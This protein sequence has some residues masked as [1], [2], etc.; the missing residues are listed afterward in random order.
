MDDVDNNIDWR[1]VHIQ[2]LIKS[3]KVKKE[4]IP[5]IIKKQEIPVMNTKCPLIKIKGKKFVVKN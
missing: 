3:Q 1:N 2:N 4:V 5:N